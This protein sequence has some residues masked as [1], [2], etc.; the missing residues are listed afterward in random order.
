MAETLFS[1]G[2]A[3][4]D[5]AKQVADSLVLSNLVGVDSHGLVRIK[6]YFDGIKAGVLVPSAQPIV[7]KDNGVAVSMD[8]N[9]A[10]GQVAARRAM[11]LAIEKAR[12][13]AIGAVSFGN[14]FHIGRLG[15]WVELAAEQGLIGLMVTNG[16]RPGGL[17]APF[18][19]R[20]RV[21]GTSTLR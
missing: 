2:G 7:L 16:G 15:E 12:E 17:V 20:Q 11:E 8:G 5:I 4:P 3:P 13:H 9:K 1:A 6:N 19:S 21:L 10:F 14:V 18:G